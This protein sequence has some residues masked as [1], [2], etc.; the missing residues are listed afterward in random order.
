MDD[1]ITPHECQSLIELGAIQG[2]LRSEDVGTE[3]KFDGSIT[4]VKSHGRTSENAWCVDACYANT[5]TS[6]VLDKLHQLTN[7]PEDH[8]EY[9]Q[10]LKYEKGQ[11]YQ[12]HHDYITLD[13]KRPQGVRIL[14]V[15]LYL[16]T[17][18][19]NQGGGT[20]FPLVNGGIT[21]QPKQGRAVIWPSVMNSDPHAIDDRT[22]HQALPVREGIKYG[23]NAWIHARD[24]KT[25]H[26]P[27]ESKWY[28]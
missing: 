24:F 17:M 18:E 16:N 11:F 27:G 9:L 1:F 23:A 19:P 2:Y 12:R 13:L 25:P 20:N 10:L 14:T 8:G 5:T 21:V 22:L 28:D 4:S 26:K 7:I 3:L 15:F 6:H